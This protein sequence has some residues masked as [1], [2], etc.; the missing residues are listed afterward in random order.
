MKNVCGCL[1]GFPA[2]GQDPAGSQSQTGNNGF[3]GFMLFRKRGS[4]RGAPYCPHMADVGTRV[5]LKLC[6]K[7]QPL[8]QIVLDLEKKLLYQHILNV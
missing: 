5:T 6:T 2:R 7:Y 1:Q 4:S 8:S 3:S